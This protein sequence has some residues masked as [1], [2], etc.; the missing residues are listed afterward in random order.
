MVPCPESQCYSAEMQCWSWKF[1]PVTLVCTGPFYLQSSFLWSSAKLPFLTPPGGSFCFHPPQHKPSI[2]KFI[3]A[4]GPLQPPSS[5]D[6]TYINEC[7]CQTSGLRYSTYDATFN[8]RT[9]GSHVSP[10]DEI[11]S[12]L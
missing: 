5:P 1:S 8:L 10:K 11:S 2:L 3:S 7:R 12:S 9:C 4:A 6:C